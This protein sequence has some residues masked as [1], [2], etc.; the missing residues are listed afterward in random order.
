MK[1]SPEIS[2]PVARLA[3]SRAELTYLLVP[4]STERPRVLVRAAGGAFPRSATMRFLSSGRTW[5]AAALLVLALLARS[6]PRTLRWLRF[7]PVKAV[8]RF[9]IHRFASARGARII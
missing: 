2:G 6:H 3:Q 8:I 1:Q 4:Q 9:V 5:E 7:L